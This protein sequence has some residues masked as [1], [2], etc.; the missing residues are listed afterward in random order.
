LTVQIHP[1]D[2]FG[3]MQ[4]YQLFFFCAGHRIV[5]AE[6]IKCADDDEAAQTARQR[7]AQHPAADSVE[8]WNRDDR[9]IVTIT[10]T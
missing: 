2:L 8:I 1:I 6:R 3:K 7:L 10:R 5:A 4:F 9:L